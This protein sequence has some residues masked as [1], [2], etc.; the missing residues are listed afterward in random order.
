MKYT[1]GDTVVAF[2]KLWFLQ[3]RH[4][5]RY[6]STQAESPFDQKPSQSLVELAVK[7]ILALLDQSSTSPDFSFYRRITRPEDR[8]SF[9]QRLVFADARNYTNPTEFIQRNIYFFTPPSVE[10][11]TETIPSLRLHGIQAP[12]LDNFSLASVASICQTLRKIPDNSW[13][14]DTIRRYLA[15]MI[16]TGLEMTMKNSEGGVIIGDEVD[17]LKLNME[18]S[19]TVLIFQYLRWALMGAR[20]GPESHVTMKLLGKEETSRRLVSA[21]AVLKQVKSNAFVEETEKL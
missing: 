16:S 5:A 20:P 1:R 10:V 13:N 18:K 3:K 19:W 14:E 17:P 8:Q 12:Y 7:P 15:K 9:V 11:L 21:E 4:A 6:A 2:E